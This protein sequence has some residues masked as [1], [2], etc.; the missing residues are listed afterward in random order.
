MIQVKAAIAAVRN[1]RSLPSDQYF[2][3]HGAFIDL[4]DFLQYCF[5]F[6]V[7]LIS[8]LFFLSRFKASGISQYPYYMFPN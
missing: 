4:F 2:Q 3:K 5:G 8:I 7:I 1:V 6:Q